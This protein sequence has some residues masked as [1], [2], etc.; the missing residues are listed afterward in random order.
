MMIRAPFSC[1]DVPLHLLDDPSARSKRAHCCRRENGPSNLQVQ[2]LHF[3]FFFFLQPFV[4]RSKRLAPAGSFGFMFHRIGLW[5]LSPSILSYY[6]YNIERRPAPCA[7]QKSFSSTDSSPSIHASSW[8]IWRS[9]R[10]S[11]LARAP[12]TA[13]D[14]AVSPRASPAPSARN[15]ERGD[16]PVSSMPTR[17]MSPQSPSGRL[18]R[19]NLWRLASSY[20]KRKKQNKKKNT[21]NSKSHL[22][23]SPANSPILQF[24]LRGAM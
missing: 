18:L 23:N 15:T 16:T 10:G 4:S 3:F 24:F 12:N 5:P 1:L 9:E 6:I 8:R 17:E 11:A 19:C 22:S 7:C 2:P 14:T 13:I 21:R 20:N